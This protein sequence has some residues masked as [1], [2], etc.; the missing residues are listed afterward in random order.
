MIIP[1]LE[2]GL[3]TKAVVSNWERYRYWLSRPL[4]EPNSTDNAVAFVMLNP[5]TADAWEDDATIRRCVG[6][7]E[8]WGHDILIVVNLYA[9]RAT[10]PKKLAKVEDPV[11]PSNSHYLSWAGLVIPRL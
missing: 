4:R 7:A 9:Y 11:G 1:K 8:A 2:Q 3:K 6:F 5:S 10:D